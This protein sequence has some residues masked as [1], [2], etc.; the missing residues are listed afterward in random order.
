MARVGIPVPVYGFFR[1]PAGRDAAGL[2]EDRSVRNQQG[3]AQVLPLGGA[4]VEV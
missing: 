3:M 2:S 4:S 1:V